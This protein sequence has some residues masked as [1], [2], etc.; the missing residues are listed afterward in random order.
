MSQK[1]S[2]F[3]KASGLAESGPPPRISVDGRLP[4]PAILTCNKTIPLR[5]LIKKLNETSE[6]LFLQIFQIV[7]IGFTKI[8]AHELERIEKS[9]WIV[10][11]M[12]NLQVPLGNSDTPVNKDVELAGEMWNRAPLP[13]TVPPS[14]ETCNLSRYY[15]LE[16][17]IGLVYGTKGNMK[18]NHLIHHSLRE[19]SD[20]RSLN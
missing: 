11:S 16:I 19:T 7:L 17:S 15:E 3:S 13:N 4:D 2:L 8:R 6:I 9:S 1:S 20:C 12:A 14:F 5:V 10:V 18:V